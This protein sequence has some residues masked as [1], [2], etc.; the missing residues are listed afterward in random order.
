M[1]TVK[2]GDIFELKVFD[3]IKE[4]LE[5]GKFGFNPE[6][7][8]IF[9]KK[10]Y[11][12]KDRLKHITFDISIETKFPN[13]DK[14][15]FLT[16]IECKSYNHRVPV[17]DVEEFYTKVNQIADLN[18]KGIFVTDNTFQEG[19]YNF[20]KSKGITLIQLQNNECNFIL[21]RTNIEKGKNKDVGKQIVELVVE[22]FEDKIEG[23]LFLS[24]NEIENIAIDFLN[25]IDSQIISRYRPTPINLIKNFVYDNNGIQIFDDKE[26]GNEENKILG[27]YKPEKKEIAIDRTIKN[28][29]SYAFVFAHE[30]GHFKLHQ[31]LKVC[32][33]NNQIFN[34]PEINFLK[35]RRELKKDR[36]W[37][38]WQANQFSA[39]LLMPSKTI[40]TALVAYQMTKGI[41]N[42]G[43]IYF[44]NQLDN[45]R[46]FFETISELA[47]YFNVAKINVEY[48]LADLG[49]IKYGRNIPKHWTK[50]I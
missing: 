47:K 5:K 23:L 29:P 42:R 30:I 8:E 48:R 45:R 44:D 32:Q 17:D 49:L 15:S 38:E 13:A 10:S 36:H 25:N 43:Q 40:E 11:Y 46:T 2:K 33:I 24:K 41:R 19:A 39:S 34:D 1:N 35:D 4:R 16:L 50:F 3:K 7:C 27:Y 37:I 26:I 9:H 20:A 21:H 31:D 14:Y 28:N 6:S 12:S 18:G 22:I